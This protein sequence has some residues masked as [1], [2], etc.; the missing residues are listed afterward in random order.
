MTEGVTI[1]NPDNVYIGADVVIGRD[2]VIYPGAML[3]GNTEIGEDCI[4][5]AGALLVDRIV[6][7]GSEIEAYTVMK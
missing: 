4:I 6:E 1:I 2:T 5:G 3:Y 7:S